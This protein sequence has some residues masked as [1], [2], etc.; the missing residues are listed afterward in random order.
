[1]DNFTARYPLNKRL[2]GCFGEKK[3]LLPLEGFEPRA[4]LFA[5]PTTLLQLVDGKKMLK[6]NLKELEYE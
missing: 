3:N 1:V 6:V 2:G 5:I 4:A